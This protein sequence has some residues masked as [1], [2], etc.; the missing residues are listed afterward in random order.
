MPKHLI[1]GPPGTGKTS[2]GIGLVDQAMTGG[3]HP[4]RILYASFT[5]AA[6]Y[7]ARRR[8]LEKF[9][10]YTEDDFPFFRTLH[11]IA[12]RLLHLDHH[13]MFD[14][15]RLKEFAEAF[16]YQFSD[17]ALEKDIFRQ[18]IVDMALGTE[19]DSYLAFDEWRKNKLIFDFD[20][21]YKGFTRW[22]IELPRDFNSRALK[23]FLE[24]KE[25]YKQAEGLWEFSDLLLRVYQ[26]EIPIDV[27]FVV[28]DECQDNSP[29]LHAVAEVWARGAK[30][31]Y[32]LGDPDQAI[33]SFMG[34]DP[35]I[36]LDWERDADREDR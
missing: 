30:E 27:D 31:V 5:R 14:G 12:F 3:I 28:I 9:L 8:A 29:L 2:H 26:D 34:A 35:S 11:S 17:D 18:D 10:E 23:L 16:K 36:M 1:I 19:A 33:Y 22:H 24:R 13:A 4:S 32:L 6:S 21:A 7:E 20:E 15:K 25:E